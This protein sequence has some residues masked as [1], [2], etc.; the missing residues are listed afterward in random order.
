MVEAHADAMRGLGVALRNQECEEGPKKGQRSGIPP[1]TH[2]GRDF[3]AKGHPVNRVSMCLKG[4]SVKHG[5]FDDG[6]SML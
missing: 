2:D 6:G 4:L 3:V 5:G 1:G